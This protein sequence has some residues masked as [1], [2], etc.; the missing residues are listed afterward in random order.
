MATRQ[1]SATS[2]RPRAAALLHL[3]RNSVKN[4]RQEI[5]F[6]TQGNFYTKPRGVRDGRYRQRMGFAYDSPGVDLGACDIR[7]GSLVHTFRYGYEQEVS[8]VS[9]CWTA[10]QERTR[11]ERTQM[12]AA[13]ET[14]EVARLQPRRRP[15][16]AEHNG[17]EYRQANRPLK[18]H[19]LRAAKGC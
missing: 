18:R 5:K 3:L 17:F 8:L 15:H 4:Q 6:T 2:A 10:Q 13:A 14:S 11:K 19:V 7:R 1:L 9:G 16:I 12:G